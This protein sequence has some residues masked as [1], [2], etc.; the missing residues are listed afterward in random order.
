LERLTGEL[1][2][3]AH[4]PFAVGAALLVVVAL[5]L[6][7]HAARWL[8]LSLLL[9]GLG[10]LAVAACFAITGGALAIPGLVGGTTRMIAAIATPWSA[11]VAA[12]G[13]ALYGFGRAQHLLRQRGVRWLGGAF[14]LSA[15]VGATAIVWIARQP[16]VGVSQ[17]AQMQLVPAEPRVR[18]A[19]RRC[20]LIT[21]GARAIDVPHPVVTSPTPRRGA[22][23]VAALRRA[24]APRERAP[25]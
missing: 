9:A 7:V 19:V 14:L 20:V 12:A 16:A 4:L 24:A 10:L 3:L 18:R 15:V 17:V 6:V 21:D 11:M 1:G 5:W 23:A 8:Y 22:R 13:L 2:V 25:R